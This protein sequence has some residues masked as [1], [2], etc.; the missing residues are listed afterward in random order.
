MLPTRYPEHMPTS[1]D[2]ASPA[3]CFLRKVLLKSAELDAL[4][5]EDLCGL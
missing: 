2:N 4:S 5:Q 3:L 1:Q